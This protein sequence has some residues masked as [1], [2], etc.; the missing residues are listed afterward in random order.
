MHECK[1]VCESVCIIN[2]IVKVIH[3]LMQIMFTMLTVSF[4]YL[5]LHE[6]KSTFFHLNHLTRIDSLITYL[7]CV[8]QR[9]L[10]V[11]DVDVCK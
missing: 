3:N 7:V 11:Q 1:N 9:T 5:I 6:S 10:H 8:V 4:D 2:T